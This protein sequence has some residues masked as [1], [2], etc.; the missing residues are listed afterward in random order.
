MIIFMSKIILHPHTTLIIL[1]TSSPTDTNRLPS[2]Q[3]EHE[4]PIRRV[5][6]IPTA[7]VPSSNNEGHAESLLH[8]SSPTRAPTIRP[9]QDLFDFIYLFVADTTF[10]IV[11]AAGRTTTTAT[12]T[13]RTT[14]M[15]RAR[16]TMK[17]P[18]R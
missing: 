12:T 18:S 4:M 13:T 10:S 9:L 3:S 8:S 14:L 6:S 7:L 1:L 11:E 17:T 5:L 2:F 16:T 15:T